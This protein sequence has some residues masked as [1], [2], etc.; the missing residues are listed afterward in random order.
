MREKI[1]LDV[2]PELLRAEW[3]ARGQPPEVVEQYVQALV[4]LLGMFPS[5]ESSED[6]R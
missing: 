2:I 1:E 5:S 4:G 3:I 6:E